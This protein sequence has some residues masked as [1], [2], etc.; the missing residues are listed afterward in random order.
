MG[1]RSDLTFQPLLAVGIGPWLCLAPVLLCFY[2]AII[3]TC[4]FII[5]EIKNVFPLMRGPRFMPASHAG[6]VHQLIKKN[7]YFM[8]PP[9]AI[10]LLQ[11][12]T[13][14]KQTKSHSTP[15][16]S[17]VVPHHT[18]DVAHWGLTSQIGRDA[19]YS[20][21]LWSNAS[22]WHYS[23]ILKLGELS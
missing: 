19:V 6:F 13:R 15:T 8:A 4:G 21:K 5:S 12:K 3:Y 22:E 11:K 9:S 16:C 7:G 23:F 18:T 17:H 2:T 10:R 20:T 1:L 14:L